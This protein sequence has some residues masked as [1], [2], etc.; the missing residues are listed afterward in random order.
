LKLK[1]DKLHSSV[2]FKF[3]LSHYIMG[4]LEV[5]V[6]G[7]DMGDGGKSGMFKAMARRCK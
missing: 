5:D 6:A 3:N 2:A 4:N 1:C 7:A